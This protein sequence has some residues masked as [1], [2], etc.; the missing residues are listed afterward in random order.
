M[1]SAVY[2]E[3]IARGSYSQLRIFLPVDV[4]LMWRSCIEVSFQ[5][6]YYQGVKLWLNRTDDKNALKWSEKEREN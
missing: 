4:V 3:I 2:F 6:R 1:F 5:V